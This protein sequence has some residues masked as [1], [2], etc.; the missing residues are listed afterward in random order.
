NSW[1]TFSQTNLLENADIPFSWHVPDFLPG[2][3]SCLSVMYVYQQMT[4]TPH[5]SEMNWSAQDV[6]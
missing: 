4:R 2:Y 1:S 6:S 3:F 5:Y